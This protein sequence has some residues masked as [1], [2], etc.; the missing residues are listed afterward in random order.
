MGWELTRAGSRA[1]PLHR[2][3]SRVLVAL[4]LLARLWP[5]HKV[6]QFA[7]RSVWLRYY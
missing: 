1:L 7:Y 4:A 6:L 3:K 2:L 5:R